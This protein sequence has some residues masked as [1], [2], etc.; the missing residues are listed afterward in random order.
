LQA[1]ARVHT[2]ARQQLGLQVA[3]LMDDLKAAQD[4]H[5]QTQKAFADTRERSMLD[6]TTRDGTLSELREALEEKTAALEDQAAALSTAKSKAERLEEELSQVQLEYNQAFANQKDLHL[7]IQDMNAHSQAYQHRR[8][9]TERDLRRKVRDSETALRRLKL[10]ADTNASSLSDTVKELNSKLVRVEESLSHVSELLTTKTKELTD[11]Q[12]ELKR[13]QLRLRELEDLVM[14]ESQARD[15]MLEQQEEMSMALEQQAAR[16]SALEEDKTAIQHELA[17]NQLQVQELESAALRWQRAAEQNQGDADGAIV[18]AKRDVDQINLTL[19]AKEDETDRLRT[20]VGQLKGSVHGKEDAIFELQQQLALAVQQNSLNATQLQRE[21]SVVQQDRSRLEKEQSDTIARLERE[22]Q[23]EQQTGSIRQRELASVQEKYQELEATLN[24]KVVEYKHH[25]QRL[26]LDLEQVSHDDSAMQTQTRRLT[27]EVRNLQQSLGACERELRQ[28]EEEAASLRQ[29]LELG[30]QHAKVTTELQV[31]TLMSQVQELERELGFQQANAHVLVA[32]D[33][34]RPVRQSSNGQEAHVQ[35]LVVQRGDVLVAIG[36]EDTDGYFEAWHQGEVGL[37]PKSFVLTMDQVNDRA[38]AMVYD[39]SAYDELKHRLDNV[40]QSLHDLT[41]Q[42][43]DKEGALQREVVSREGLEQQVANSQVTVD[44]LTRK[45]HEMQFAV[46]RSAVVEPV[47]GTFESL[48]HTIE[49]L[50]SQDMTNQRIIETLRAQL[51][52]LQH[53]ASEQQRQARAAQADHGTR[54]NLQTIQIDELEGRL[55]DSSSINQRLRREIEQLTARLQQVVEAEVGE[56]RQVDQLTIQHRNLE[57]KHDKLRQAYADVDD[58]YQ[59]A[60]GEVQRQRNQLEKAQQQHSMLLSELEASKVD[61]RSQ[62]LEQQRL[63]AQLSSLTSDIKAATDAHRSDRELSGLLSNQEDHLTHEVARLQLSLEQEQRRYV[64]MHDQL[65]GRVSQLQEKL[66]DTEGQLLFRTTDAQGA[67][68]AASSAQVGALQDKVASLAAALQLAQEQVVEV[69]THHRTGSRTLYSNSARLHA[70]KIYAELQ[71]L[72]HVLATTS[73]AVNTPHSRLVE[74]IGRLEASSR[75]LQEQLTHEYHQVLAEN[76]TIRGQTRGERVI[77]ARLERRIRVLEEQLAQ[78][79]QRDGSLALQAEIQ[80]YAERELDLLAQVDSLEGEA[81][82]LARDRGDLLEAA[83][84]QLLA[85]R[86][87]RELVDDDQVLTSQ[88]D[89]DT[90]LAFM[91]NVVR[92]LVEGR[93]MIVCKVRMFLLAG[94]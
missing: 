26:Q 14:S 49:A 64:Q 1:E 50:S 92:S 54:S 13:R 63:Q 91:P 8:E 24:S 74:R 53:Q 29:Q 76:Q 67:T 55:A 16:A 78:S 89:L 5:N 94:I 45:L 56:T 34:Y 28:R 20:Q 65:Q 6:V 62:R 79:T 71:T 40:S 59:V 23:Q 70:S 3:Q 38:L 84:R 90:D 2:E 83:R 22:L 11:V 66:L 48:N 68:S 72:Q 81:E 82:S 39:P 25:V 43:Q 46:H 18:Q 69:L 77:N 47:P 87:M 61:F 27:T 21:F 31:Q 12:D 44:Q 19:L 80:Y 37:V 15:A 33:D 93:I 51:Q 88:E 32:L 35:E 41:D 42:L 85:C 52:Q 57:E 36:T 7:Q 17:R 4:A 73:S 86:K 60:A 10:S 30:N 58:R 9:E 75:R